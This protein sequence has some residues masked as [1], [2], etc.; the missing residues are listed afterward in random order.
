MSLMTLAPA[1]TD[2]PH[3]YFQGRAEA[4]DDANTLTLD[5][6]VVRGGIY[7]D[8]ADLMYA[9]GYLDRV[10][11]LRLEHDAVSGAEAELA[12]ANRKQP[13]R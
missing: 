5:Q 6:L 13:T 10:L 7:G 2:D 4:H 3:A 8:H 1:T 11:E 9:L 12:H